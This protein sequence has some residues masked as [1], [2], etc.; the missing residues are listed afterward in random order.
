M[1]LSIAT[2][3][4]NVPQPE[5]GPEILDLLLDGGEVAE[6]LSAALER[7]DPID[8]FLLAAAFEQVVQ[9]H[10][11]RDPLA[12]QR[13][14]AVL[15]GWGRGGRLAGRAARAAAGVL[16]AVR[17]ALPRERRLT[18]ALPGLAAI[19]DDL[20]EAVTGGL[21]SPAGMSPRWA[22]VMARVGSGDPVRRAVIRLPSC[23]RDLDQRPED[24]RRLARAV[25]AAAEPGER[26][27]VVGVR[28]SGSFLAPLL[29]AWLRRTGRVAEVVTMRP[30]AGWSA[31]ELRRLRRAAAA[32]I[33]AL[34]V[35]DPPSSGRALH[36]AARALEQAGFARERRLLAFAMLDEAPPARLAGERVAA[37]PF[38]E[39]SI[40]AALSEERVHRALARLLPGRPVRV[41]GATVIVDSVVEV[42]RDAPAL[43]PADRPRSR[44]HL[45]GTYRVTVSAAG[46]RLTTR[47]HARGCGPGF[48]GR[49]ALAVSDRLGDLVPA[50]YG[51]ADGLLYREWVEGGTPAVPL[52][53]HSVAAL[54][55]GIAG[56]VAARRESLAVGADKSLRLAGRNPVW[57]RAADV[58]AI[59]YRRLRPV[60]RTPLHRAAI[61]LLGAGAPALTDGDMTAGRWYWTA[62]GQGPARLVKA[63]HDE[64][65]F[66][67]EDL[68]C[69]DPDFDLAAASA[70]FEIG[71][72]RGRQLA[73]LLRS[74]A[75]SDER[76]TLYR[77]ERLQSARREG[78]RALAR[79][80]GEGRRAAVRRLAAI[81]VALERT[82]GEYLGRSSGLAGRPVDTGGAMCA[83]DVDGVLET[84][85]GG[86]SS[87]T[88]AGAR[89]LGA[90]TDH[91]FTP[92]LATGRSLDDVRW[93]CSAYG[94]RGAVA[95]Y[96]CVVWV[97]G[98]SAAEDLVAPGLGDAI[99]QLR[100]RLAEAG[101]EVDQGFRWVTRASVW[102][103]EEGRRAPDPGVVANAL[104]GLEQHFRLVPGWSQI[105]L[106]PG[107]ADK[108]LGLR[109]LVEKL[110]CQVGLAPPLELAMG[111]SAS[112]LPML[113]LA[114][115]AVA[116]AN[117]RPSLGTA[118]GVRFT[119]HEHQRGL[120]EAVAMLTGHRPAACGTCRG[121]RLTPEA[122]LLHGILGAHDQPRALRPLRVWALMLEAGR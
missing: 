6:H 61:R 49:H 116:P 5:R 31:A 53:R 34:A 102:T 89:A 99:A 120:G 50:A 41:G 45:E 14:A 62:G 81:E 7:Q 113:R 98:E 43:D 35:D 19:V 9:D 15:E 72:R 110:G 4:E 39:W 71:D 85:A 18:G 77:L 100:G 11:H 82:A 107:G 10:L 122:R 22:T 13:V 78:L 83:I 60:L 42:A 16:R 44:R 48:L 119:R 47:V 33:T 95:E 38:E 104:Q 118:P 65:A 29:A 73:D 63:G 109:V 106:V 86:Y 92:V 3:A 103:P 27:L 37:L 108:N 46:A 70:E 20:A 66:S 24:V 58:L 17:A 79:L 69:Y 121:P 87:T 101:I 117:G 55:L 32:G 97:E 75:A 76:W 12:I 111:D 2:A 74:H 67:N 56:Y 51:I 25:L 52:G 115:L 59:R 94:L 57:Q 96:G 105:D 36:R 112:D 64:L 90:L 40:H 1:T 54:A 93:R 68:A 8:A 114:R 91:G 80:T 88:P 26:F 21:A 84:D 30:G 23:F 28:T